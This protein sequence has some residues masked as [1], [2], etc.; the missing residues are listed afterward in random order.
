[1][2]RKRP[3][4]WTSDAVRRAADWDEYYFALCKFNGLCA[5]GSGVPRWL[6]DL[7]DI[8]HPIIKRERI[9]PE[10][11]EEAF[12]A[13]LRESL[14]YFQADLGS[15][16]AIFGRNFRRLLYRWRRKADALQEQ[17]A[18]DE[19]WE[20]HSYYLWQTQRRSRDGE[21]ER[22]QELLIHQALLRLG[23][24]ALLLWA[25]VDLASGRLTNVDAVAKATATCR[26]TLWRRYG[27]GRLVEEVKGMLRQMVDDL[28]R[29]HRRILIH[30]LETEAELTASEIEHL[31]DVIIPDD[32]DKVRG[33]EEDE[34]LEMLGWNLTNDDMGLSPRAL[35]NAGKG[36]LK[37]RKTSMKAMNNGN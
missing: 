20:R 6:G 37:V 27:D 10:L 26:S 31:L 24:A 28:P 13:A 15:V 34:L 36:A 19:A 18:T 3:C 21:Y 11:A 7:W 9:E 23:P 17:E 35:E 14:R 22:W 8:A 25:E 32:T 16:Q 30:H 4:E 5:G 29:E 33:M 1:M 2:F 12:E